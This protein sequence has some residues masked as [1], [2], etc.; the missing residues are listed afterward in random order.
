MRAHYNDGND[1]THHRTLAI[2]GLLLG[3]ASI[4]KPRRHRTYQSDA[5]NAIALADSDPGQV[6]ALLDQMKYK[7]DG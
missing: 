5:C 1:G 3:C 7:H 6:R 2:G 4:C